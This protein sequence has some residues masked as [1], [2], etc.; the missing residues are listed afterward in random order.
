[1]LD[2]QRDGGVFE[3]WG[4]LDADGA[5]ALLDAVQSCD[6]DVRIDASNVESIDGAGLTALAGARRRCLD[7]GRWFEVATVAATA[8]SGLRARRSVTRLF[9]PRPTERTTADPKPCAVPDP[10]PMR[11]RRFRM[12]LPRATHDEGRGTDG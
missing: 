2:V 10:R 3:L 1:M 4:S 7:D 8:I 12:R 6:G 9:G 5:T 11:R